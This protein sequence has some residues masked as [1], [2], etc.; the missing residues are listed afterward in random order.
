M[1]KNTLFLNV[2]KLAFVLLILNISPVYAED[3][4]PSG[5]KMMTVKADPQGVALNEWDRYV[6]KFRRDHNLSLSIG[7]A[8]TKWEVRKFGDLRGKNYKSTQESFILDYSFH[9]LIAGKSGYFLGTNSGYVYTRPDNIDNEF[10]P[11]HSWLL[12]G[13]RGGVVYNYDSSGRIFIGGGAQLERF[14]ELRTHRVTGDWNNAAMTGESVQMFAG[15]DLFFSLNSSIHFAWTETRCTLQKPQ[16][17]TDY[18]V[19]AT[20]VKRSL[21]GELGLLYHFL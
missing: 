13:V 18:L 14:N 16:E 5:D 2:R 11:S 1:Q 4:A 17:S 8:E 7:F 20:I 9:I 21:G 12:P 3:A 10:R 6:R 15:M 19:N